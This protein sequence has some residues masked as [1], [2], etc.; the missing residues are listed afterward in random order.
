MPRTTRDHAGSLKALCV[1]CGR[2]PGDGK[3]RPVKEAWEPALAKFVP[4]FSVGSVLHPQSICS[5]CRNILAPLFKDLNANVANSPVLVDWDAMMPRA[6][7]SSGKTINLNPGEVCPCG[8]CDIARLN[9]VDFIAWHKAHS[10]PAGLPPKPPPVKNFIKRCGDCHAE[11]GPGKPHSCNKTEKRANLTGLIRY[12]SA[13]TQTSVVANSLK[14]IAEDQGASSRGGEVSLQSGGP[15]KLVVK[16][17]KGRKDKRE[18]RIISHEDLKALQLRMGCSDKKLMAINQFLASVLGQKK[19]EPYLKDALTARNNEM[20]DFFSVSNMTFTK[21]PKAK[22]EMVERPVITADIPALV[23][24]LINSRG[25]D[26]DN[27]TLQL[28]L[29]GGQSI[30]KICLLVREAVGEEVGKF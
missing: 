25:L 6:S 17:G 22:T 28:G 5:T 19:L 1:C 26:P 16:I 11:I 4:G 8:I 10:R 23:T 3:L 2:K 30:L 18:E 15:N 7:R 13:N 29:D 12:N 9:G 14:G 21:G 24:F 20:K 27:H